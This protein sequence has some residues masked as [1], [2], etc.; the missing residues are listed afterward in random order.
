M[1]MQCYIWD[2]GAWHFSAFDFRT[3]IADQHTS[4]AS[5]N[6]N[7]ESHCF[8]YTRKYQIHFQLYVL[9]WHRNKSWIKSP[10]LFL[11][12]VFFRMW[13]HLKV[14]RLIPKC[15]ESSAMCIQSEMINYICSNFEWTSIYAISIYA[16]IIID[17]FT[18]RHT[19]AALI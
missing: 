17:N 14:N 16:K 6:D 9:C 2:I 10:F 5:S 1:L 11:F 4:K 13:K 18:F 12:V 8:Y 3:H 19:L 15:V 7:L